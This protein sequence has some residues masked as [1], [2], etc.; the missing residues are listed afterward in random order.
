MLKLHSLIEVRQADYQANLSH[1]DHDLAFDSPPSATVR[2]H[3]VKPDASGQP[4]HRELSK[5]LAKYITTYCVEAERRKDLLE[6]ERNE[7]FMQARD[8]F[9]RSNNSGQVGELLT[10]FLLET[11]LL[12]PQVLKK[13]PMTTNPKEERKGSDGI[14]MRWDESAGVLDVIFAESK[15][16][17]SFSDALADTFKSV[18]GFHD[19]RTKRHEINAVTAGYS[20]LDDET[21]KQVAAYIDGENASNCR[22]VQ[23]CL[24]GFNWSEYECLTDSRRQG[25]VSEFELRYRGWAAEIRNSLND[26]LRAC[27]HKHLQFEFFMLPF[28]DVATFR[29]WFEE[30]LTGTT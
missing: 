7:M 2:L 29:A 28:I 3:F 6:V 22:H 24:I 20:N 5:T 14:H 25:F 23:A 15:I 17:A 11:V 30:D 27:Q 18:Q 21:K 19:S 4:R 1:V 10:Y 13:M 8:L 9:R 16:W 26:K 12:A